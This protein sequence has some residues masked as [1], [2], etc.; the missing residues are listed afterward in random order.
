MEQGSGIC[1]A[2]N[3]RGTGI[4]IQQHPCGFKGGAS[5]IGGVGQGAVFTQVE[6]ALMGVVLGAEGGVGVVAEPAAVVATEKAK[7]MHDCRRVWVKCP[8]DNEN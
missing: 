7:F 3:F 2:R 6:A 8:D 5:L 4:Y 1:E